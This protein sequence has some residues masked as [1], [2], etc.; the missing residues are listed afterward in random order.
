M[1]HLVFLNWMTSSH[2]QNGFQIG[3]DLYGVR[4]SVK[5]EKE[6]VVNYLHN[7]SD[8]NTLSMESPAVMIA[9]HFM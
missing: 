8:N 3:S 7:L 6:S 5:L 1:N 4:K 2:F 9:T